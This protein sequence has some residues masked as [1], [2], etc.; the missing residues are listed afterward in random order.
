L[1][2]AAVIG[3]EFPLDLVA[4]LAGLAHE[5]QVQLLEEATAARLVDELPGAVARYR[6]AHSL[7]R[8]VCYERL[9]PPQRAQ[10]HRLAGET[11]EERCSG[12]IDDYLVELAYHFAQAGGGNVPKAVDYASRAGHQ[13]YE[14][15]AYE[16]AVSHY[17]H[18]LQLLRA[19]EP[20][21]PVTRCELLLALGMAQRAAS[22]LP[23]A[24][25][26]YEQAAGLARTMGAGPLL[27]RAALGL[28]VE[29][30]SGIVDD[31]E[32]K[33]LEEA[34]DLLGDTDSALRAR[35]LGRL[36][37]ALLFTPLRDRRSMLCDQA[38]A[39]ARRVGDPA[40][41]AEVLYEWHVATWSA[42][43]PEERLDVATEVVRLAERSGDR[44]LAL[45]GRALRLGD[46]LELGDMPALEAE[47]EAYD[48][49]TSA[50][51]QLHYRWHIPLLRATQATLA[52]RFEEAERLAEEGLA[53]G[54]RVQHQ[55]VMVFFPVAIA[56]IRFAQ[57]RY[58]E[59]E[60][61]LRE[62]VRR[63]PALPGWRASL[64]YA[65]A[66]AGRQAEA[67]IEYE[68][69][70]IDDFAGLPR[71]FTWVTNLTFLALVCGL[72]GDT[73]RAGMLYELL[74]PHAAENVRVSRIGVGSAGPVA[75]YLA[76]LAAT[77]GRWD[78]A[79]RHFEAAIRMNA[80]TGAAPFMVN[81]WYHYAQT[82]RA[83]GRTGDQ[84]QA[85]EHL[86]RAVATAQALG[87][88][89]PQVADAR[90]PAQDPQPEPAKPIAR[91]IARESAF[92]K[93]GEFWTITYRS[94]SFR[95][96]DRL[97]LAYLAR[98]LTQPGHE[99][100][101]LDLVTWASG[102]GNGSIRHEPFAAAL[103]SD[104]GEAVL[105]QQTKAAYRSRLT[106]LAA[107][108]E[109][110]ESWQD[111][112]RAARAKLEIDA[113]TEQLAQAVGL[114]G[115]DRTM[116]NDAERAR[117]SVTKAIKNAIRRIAAHDAALG[118]HLAHSVKTGIFVVY[119]PDPAISVSW[120]VC[121]T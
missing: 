22:Q 89:L 16:E 20:A 37:K 51:R 105:D 106:E 66:D 77:R 26:T 42:A 99:L 110:A 55:G 117:V 64:A 72:L 11:I 121:S 116:A 86:A 43:N 65:L 57:G 114:G 87:I 4:P 7:V 1:S 71:D 80:R 59:L 29:F 27:A 98:L 63:Y 46:L 40:T 70:A 79:A 47:I 50:L 119:A 2:A 78:D 31:L 21:D 9:R 32:V 15:L 91:E 104:G 61:L 30:T 95:L 23:A 18:A 82:L 81:S 12:Q 24:R 68:R 54:E 97:G 10:L 112:E 101:A 44:A 111:M 60:P 35:V 74:L 88:R 90:G 6:F 53:L 3:D 25:E 108:L 58:G 34:L 67:R 19:A 49:L 56:M 76:L 75:H 39:T 62:Q 83:R 38:V 28:S 85:Q 14:R 5:R 52:G 102:G 33:L 120:S 36:A 48:R 45:Q 69:L 84:E 93:E 100:H 17:V 109:E 92:S 113:L 96:K 73:K 13:A 107:E 41:L 115:R 94:R 118:E 8:E 103:R